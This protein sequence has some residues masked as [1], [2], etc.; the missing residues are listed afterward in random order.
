LRLRIKLDIRQERRIVKVIV[1]ITLFARI[2]AFLVDF[3]Q[4]QTD[5][6]TL[7]LGCIRLLFRR[8]VAHDFVFVFSSACMDLLQLWKDHSELSLS[9]I[10]ECFFAVSFQRRVGEIPARVL[11]RAR[12]A[13][14][15][16]TSVIKS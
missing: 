5:L 4:T 12:P 15:G 6:D 7:V 1:L 3:F 14:T 8:P 13:E 11:C 16:K 10:L 9:W 2:D